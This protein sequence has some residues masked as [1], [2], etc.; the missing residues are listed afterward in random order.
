[1]SDPKK[2]RI[3]AL[4]VW[5]MQTGF[6]LGHNG[7][8]L[9]VCEN[10]RT[11]LIDIHLTKEGENGERNQSILRR[12]F[13]PKQLENFGMEYSLKAYRLILTQLRRV[14]VCDLWEM[15]YV[16]S[17]MDETRFE[18]A[19]KKSSPVEGNGK[20]KKLV[21]NWKSTMHDMM[22]NGPGWVYP[23]S[24][25]NTDDSKKVTGLIMGLSLK[26]KHHHKRIG[27]INIPKNGWDRWYALPF[28]S[29]PKVAKELFP[30]E[31]WEKVQDFVNQVLKHIPLTS[32]ETEF[33]LSSV[34]TEETVS[35]SR[36]F[37]NVF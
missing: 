32:L 1:M 14:K 33:D 18:A 8:H 35:N 15:G 24:F 6:G 22:V 4:N 21:V 23:P 26:K 13:T 25:L 16:V 5:P 28:D 10:I 9:T 34:I 17:T 20:H 36:I 29:M 2:F 7:Y 12:E 30:A 31:V 3:G 19:L 11:H 37:E 27:L